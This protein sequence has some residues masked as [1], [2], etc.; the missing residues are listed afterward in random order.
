MANYEL[1]AKDIM[2]VE[3]ATILDDATISEAIH[4]MRYEGVRS[5]V[6]VPYSNGD[7]FGIITYADIVNKILADKKDPEAVH[8]HDIMTK[9]AITIPPT[10][11]VDHIANLFRSHHFGHVLVVDCGELHGIVSM[12][13]L[14]VEVVPEPEQDD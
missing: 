7:P 9:P 14:I 8:V 6:V 10:M 11:R 4:H 5:L 13:D 2:Q 1:C 12:T 3:V